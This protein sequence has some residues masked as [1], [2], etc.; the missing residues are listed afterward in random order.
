MLAGGAAILLGL[1][2]LYV[3]L[4][5]DASTEARDI[6]RKQPIEFIVL[7]DL[8]LLASFSILTSVGIL[9]R[10]RPAV[11]KRAM[12]LANIALVTPALGRVS[13][14][15]VLGDPGIALVLPVVLSLMLAIWVHDFLSG[16]RVHATTFWGSALIFGGLLASARLA[17]TESGKAFV[18][19]ISLG[20][21]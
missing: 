11:H 16:K 2:T 18:T 20:T 9:F 14:F 5:A 3:I 13:R 17:G 15:P 1:M 7:G 19:A 10:H 6:I 21:G 8:S 12:L 4:G